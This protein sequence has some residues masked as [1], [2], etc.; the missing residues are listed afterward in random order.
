MEFASMNEMFLDR[1]KNFADH[2]VYWHKKDGDWQA[3]TWRQFAKTIRNLALSLVELGLGKGD[4]VCVLSN[5]RWEWDACDKAILMFG[6]V[7]VGIYQT[8]PPEQVQYVISHSEARAII[9]ENQIQF[10]KVMEVMGNCPNLEHLIVINPEGCEG[11]D[12]SLFSDMITDSSERE[13]KFEKKLDR[14]I[15]EVGHDDMATLIYTSGTTGPPK[16]AMITHYNLLCEARLLA[17]STELDSKDD[18]TLTWLP[19]A[20]IFQ[21]AA[22]SAGTWGAVPTY[23]AEG[24]D[25]LVDNLQETKPTIFYSVPRIFEKAYSK[26]LERADASGSPKK[27]IF[28]WSIGVGREVSKLRQ[29][30]KPIPALL[31]IKFRIAKKFVFEKI[32]KFFGGRIR[33]IASSG[34]PIGRE[35][36]EFFH[37]ADIV[38]LEAYGATETTAAITFNTPDDYRFGTVGKVAKG[39]EIKIAPDGEILIKGDMVYKGYYKEKEKTDE[40]LSKDGWYATGDV[41]ELDQDDFLKITDRK[42]DII[43]TSGG[44]NVAPQNI[45]NQLKQSFY[46]SQAMVHGDRRKYL[47]CLLTLEPENLIPWAKEAGLSTGD[48]E[49]LVKDPKVLELVN[50]EVKKVNSKLAKFETV[51][52]FTIVPEDFTIESGELTPTFKL[53]RKNITKRYMDILDSMYEN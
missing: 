43:V 1:A 53:K 45:E 23:Y 18:S 28:Y 52:Y 8:I 4:K 20:H 25:K 17:T 48:W 37:A 51:K 7:T 5:T 15:L 32:K 2:R 36:L 47:T 39:M 9:I 13:E 26:I 42:K 16:G 40:V 10:E 3:V 24:I 44:K 29:E 38:A 35:I 31:D 49:K 12:F 21:R 50:E 33:F 34:A 30:N 19:F 27:Q 11:A 6:G 22:T 41:G 46:I 14:M